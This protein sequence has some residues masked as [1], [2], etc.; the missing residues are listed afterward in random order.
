MN[1]GFIFDETQSD[2]VVISGIPVTITDK[3]YIKFVLKFKQF[4]IKKKS[5]VESCLR[6]WY[7]IYIQ[8][9]RLYS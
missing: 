7:E 5:D 1:T 4:N 6:A 9:L 8:A 3:D 2:H